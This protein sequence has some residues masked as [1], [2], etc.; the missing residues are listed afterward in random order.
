MDFVSPEFVIQEDEFTHL[1]PIDSGA[2]GAIQK[3]KLVGRFNGIM[4]AMKTICITSENMK[5][6][7]RAEVQTY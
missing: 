5:R 2:A 1:T 6:Q 7:A 4:A 3:V